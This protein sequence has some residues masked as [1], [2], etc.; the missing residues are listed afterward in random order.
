MKRGGVAQ[1]Y[2]DPLAVRVQSVRMGKEG[3]GWKRFLVFAE[4]TKG[5]KGADYVALFTYYSFEGM[6]SWSVFFY[7]PE[8]TYL[9]MASNP[10]RRRT[11]TSYQC[12]HSLFSHAAES[13]SNRRK[14]S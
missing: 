5:K 11:A 14:C 1:S 2:L 6:S 13:P 4:L 8:L 10:L 9:S 12:T 7:F 3:R